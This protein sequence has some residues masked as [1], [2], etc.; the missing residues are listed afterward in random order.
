MPTACAP[1][2][3]NRNASRTSWWPSR[4]TWALVPPM[5]NEDTADRRG[6]PRSGHAVGSV[7]S[8]TAPPDQSTREVGRVASRVA[9]TDPWRMAM[10]MLITPATPAAAWVCPRVDFT[11]PTSRGVARSPP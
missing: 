1:C 9:G 3:A 2:P 10:T 11:D 8:R 4:T 6:L 7:A 5:P